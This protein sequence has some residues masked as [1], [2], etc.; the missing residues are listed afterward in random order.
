VRLGLESFVGVMTPSEAIAAMRRGASAVKLF[1]AEIGGP[2]FLRAVRAPLPDYE[3]I[4]V[5]GVT[6]DLVGEYLD[7]GA[8][9]LGVGSPLTGSASAV[10]DLGLIRERVADYRAAIQG[11]SEKQ[12][13]A[14]R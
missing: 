2:A 8:L 13:Q 12:G 9:A 5:G 1:P 11:W 6:L 10:P 14:P 7:A 3:F 4:P